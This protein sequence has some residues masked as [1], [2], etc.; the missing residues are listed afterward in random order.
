MVTSVRFELPA[1]G[2][3]RRLR[4]ALCA[5]IPLVVLTVVVAFAINFRGALS[6]DN[7]TYTEMAHG[8]KVHGLPY[9]YNPYS[10]EFPEAR[11][12]WN[13]EK[14]GKLWGNY[15]PLY[16]FVGALGLEL[17]SLTGLARENVILMAL[18][19]FTLFRLGWRLTRDPLLGVAACYLALFA[20]P[21]WVGSMQTLSLPLLYLCLALA[22]L[23]AVMA[24]DRR[25]SSTYTFAA[26][27]GLFCG[28]STATHLLAFP[29]TAL[30]CVALAYARTDD[31]DVPARWWLPTPAAMGRAASAAVAMAVTLIP[32]ALLNHV[33]FGTYNPISYGP[34][35]WQA[36]ERITDNALSATSLL[37]FALVPS[38]YFL[39]VGVGLHYARQKGPLAIALVLCVAA[40]VLVLPFAFANRAYLMLRTVFGYVVDLS[41]LDVKGFNPPFPMKLG[42]ARG[43]YVVKAL[44]QTSPILVLALFAPLGRKERTAIV[45][46]PVLGLFASLALLARFRGEFAFGSPYVFMRY[47]LPAAALL[48]L[49]AV[50]VLAK[51]PWRRS[52]TLM[53]SACAIALIA[54]LAP[55]TEDYSF[56]R[57]VV[58]LCGSL[59]V[60]AWAGIGVGIARRRRSETSIRWAALGAAAAVGVSIGI[61][62]GVDTSAL[63]RAMGFLNARVDAFTK[64]TPQRF[65]VVGYG[66]ELNRVLA[67][68]TERDINY[69]D[70]EEDPEEK[71]ENK[72]RN[73]RA[74]IELWTDDGRPIFGAFPN[75][76]EHDFRWPYA[77]WDVPA[78][79]VDEAEGFW[80]IGPPVRR[81]PREEVEERRRLMRERFPRPPANGAGERARAAP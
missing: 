12:P 18:F 70:L 9:T 7:R 76:R 58:I 28:L 43:G 49:L 42:H 34:C 2:S 56:A 62:I 41:V 46:F 17:D 30:L 22:V 45:A 69:I 40:V 77:D 29:M 64:I 37:A 14:G 31:D 72:W 55:V 39:I 65:A 79:L 74:L 10:D 5:L 71:P 78:V 36:C 11:P 25:G 50:C 52:H 67:L 44:L 15:P 33:R 19:G 63:V 6:V 27:A 68:R 8:V 60:A 3:T 54:Y 32:V 4:L 81:L 59:V 73:F 20:T 26:V 57:R 51:L 75:A 1:V 24:V 47:S 53:A 66:N 38:V 16:A 80:K 48:P 21:I 13:V 35:E 61:T 23:F